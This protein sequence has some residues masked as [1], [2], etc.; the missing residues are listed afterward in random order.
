M[1]Q[2]AVVLTAA[3]LVNILIRLADDLEWSGWTWAPYGVNEGKGITI[4]Q[5][6]GRVRAPGHVYNILDARAPDEHRRLHDERAGIPCLL[7]EPSHQQ[8]LCN[9]KGWAVMGSSLHL[10]LYCSIVRETPNWGPEWFRRL[11]DQLS[12]EYD[13]DP[14]LD[15]ANAIR[16]LERDIRTGGL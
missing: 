11:S 7:F 14:K 10:E 3:E 1:G 8:L 5:I 16:D 9:D 13:V 2:P 12:A 6:M 4:H 15:I